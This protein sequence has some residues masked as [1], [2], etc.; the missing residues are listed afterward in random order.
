MA[1]ILAGCAG[2]PLQYTSLTEQ[3]P[4]GQSDVEL[5][6]VPFHPQEAYQCGP[7]ALA[8][9]MNW[10][11]EA[12][13]PDDLAPR[14]Y[15]P[16]RQGSLQTELIA[17]TRRQG[18]VPYVHRPSLSDLLAEVRNDT[19]VLVMQNLGLDSVPIWHYAVVVGFDMERQTVVLRSGT[20]KREVL[21]MRRFER[22][23][24]KADYWALTVHPPDRLPASA[25]QQ[26]YLQ[27][28]APLE[29]S[30]PD[31]AAS[32]YRAALSRWPDSLAAL[33][34]LGNLRYTAGD[35]AEAAIHYRQA[36][37]AHPDNPAAH[38][39]LAWALIR[40]GHDADALPHA[41]RAA[42][43]ADRNQPHYRSALDTLES[44]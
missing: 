29:S 19:P 44:R 16:E 42:L 1:T 5:E 28:V 43:L 18:L 38:H 22:T 17:A 34:G 3:S 10:A 6:R 8:T 40:Q 21:T 12:V 24:Q 31:S 9:V 32:A 37:A 11:G 15:L 30:A 7:A 33:I 39:N 23:W 26:R 2:A 13:H 20:E 4:S 36:V 14:V 35:H 25:D 41:R 27:A